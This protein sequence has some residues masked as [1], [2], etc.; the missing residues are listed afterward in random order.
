[1]TLRTHILALFLAMALV[2][3]MVAIS[4]QQASAIAI[5]SVQAN[6]LEI[7]RLDQNNQSLSRNAVEPTESK[8]DDTGNA[9]EPT[10][11]KRDDTSLTFKVN[12]CKINT[13][14]VSCDALSKVLKDSSIVQA[15][16][17]AVISQNG[18][19][20]AAILVAVAAVII[21]IGN[22]ISKAKEDQAATKEKQATE[23]PVSFTFPVRDCRLDNSSETTSCTQIKNM[24]RGTDLRILE[25]K[26]NSTTSDAALI[27]SIKIH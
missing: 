7:G 5:Y 22:I 2:G 10:E 19:V 15:S 11:S 23:S 26:V 12:E 24:L 3:A 8:R 4:S 6:Q 20:I 27:Q 21:L 9:V 18:P 14:S 1:M 25:L 17:E 16:I 13:V